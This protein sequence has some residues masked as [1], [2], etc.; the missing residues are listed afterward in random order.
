VREDWRPN[1]IQKSKKQSPIDRNIYH[2][3]QK[4][5][6]SA[7]HLSIP[8]KI[9]VK[10]TINREETYELIVFGQYSE[11][12]QA[13][14]LQYEE[15]AEEGQVRTTIKIS[16]DEA[17]LLRSGAIKMRLP[18]QLHKKRAGSYEPPFGRFE[19]TTQA[20]R[21]EHT[22]G[23]INIVYEFALQGAPAGQYHLEITFQEEKQ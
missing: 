20:K 18:F 8:V 10:T 13:A 19:A 21:I 23:K 9:N 4:Q 1:P 16:A 7:S 15:A 6:G 3:F 12:N 17:L 2:I 22:P 5:K 14:Y 11:K